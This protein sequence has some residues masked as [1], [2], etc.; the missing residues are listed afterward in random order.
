[1]SKHQT[2]RRRVKQ[3]KKRIRIKSEKKYNKKKNFF[4]GNA[5][6]DLNTHDNDPA[7]YM[8]ATRILPNMNG[9]RKSRNTKRGKSLIYKHSKTRTKRMK[10]GSPAVL[11]GTDIMLRNP[12][13]STLGFA[14]SIHGANTVSG[15]QATHNGVLDGIHVGNNIVA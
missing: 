8:V 1:M 14:G 2:K 11:I 13:S 5:P 15:I 6:Y 4:G 7:S 12:I 10:G 9:G 3:I